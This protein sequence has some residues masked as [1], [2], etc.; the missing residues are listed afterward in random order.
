MATVSYFRETGPV[1]RS[2]VRRSLVRVRRSYDVRRLGY[3]RVRRSYIRS[4]ARS[5]DGVRRSFVRR[6]GSGPLLASSDS[7]S[8]PTRC[9]RSHS[10]RSF[11][12]LAD[13]LVPLFFLRYA[14]LLIGWA[15]KRK[16]LNERFCVLRLRRTNCK[17]P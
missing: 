7:A 10:T 9:I 16:L 6:S 17:E 1:R 2:F 3:V 12:S 15:T 5:Y 13:V 8:F 11:T 4:Y 14:L